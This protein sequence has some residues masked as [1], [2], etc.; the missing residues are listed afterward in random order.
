MEYKFNS[1]LAAQAKSQNMGGAFRVWALCKW[2]DPVG[3][4]TVNKSLIKSALD[5]FGVNKSTARRWI[6]SAFENEFISTRAGLDYCRH[7]SPLELAR[8]LGVYHLGPPTK[9]YDIKDFFSQSWGIQIF[10]C[11]I[12]SLE[13]NSLNGFTASRATIKDISGIAE[14]TQRFYIRKGKTTAVRNAA[15]ISK[16]QS[17]KYI[18]TGGKDRLWGDWLVRI[19]PSTHTSPMRTVKPGRIGTHNR[20]LRNLVKVGR[21]KIDQRYFHSY[22]QAMKQEREVYLYGSQRRGTNYW[23]VLGG[24]TA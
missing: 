7:I 20:K 23:R 21:D 5:N 18:T 11:L 24:E 4:G 6:K 1:E 14:S 15:V 3:T 12:S 8:I 16:G 10:D 9:I 17:E 2:L 22:S 13:G 19:I